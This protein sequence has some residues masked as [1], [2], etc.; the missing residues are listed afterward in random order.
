LALSPSDN[1]G[2]ENTPDLQKFLPTD[3]LVTAPDIIFFWVAR[4]IMATQ[5]FKGQIPYR[6][7]YFTSMIRDGLGRK[8]SKSLGNSPDPLNIIAKYGADAVRFSVAYLAP[9]GQDV[10]MEVDVENQDI[11]SMEIGRN[12]ANKV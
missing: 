10:R 8:L 1:L 4:M 12:F 6:N 5:H 2:G 7:V 3:L 11:P 9:L